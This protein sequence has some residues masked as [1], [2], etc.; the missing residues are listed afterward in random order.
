MFKGKS[1]AKALKAE[2]IKNEITGVIKD[3]NFW[4]V[5]RWNWR[6]TKIGNC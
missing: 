2:E 6:H 5:Y 1:T 4:L 3:L